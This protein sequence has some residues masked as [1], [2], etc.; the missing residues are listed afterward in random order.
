VREVRE[1]VFYLG[2][3]VQMKL[4]MLIALIIALVF[5]VDGAIFLAE[6]NGSI[7][8]VGGTIN[9]L[10][11]AVFIFLAACIQHGWLDAFDEEHKK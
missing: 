5:L 1:E 8:I 11:A 4:E 7:A 10:A 6:L 2:K 3:R 9:L